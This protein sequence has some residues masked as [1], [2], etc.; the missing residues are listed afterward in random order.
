M[1]VEIEA[2]YKGDL[3]CDARHLD[4]D[5]VITTEAPKDN[6]GGGSKFSPTDLVAA[7]L[8]TCV[9]TIM[10]LYAKRRSIEIEGTKIRIKKEMSDTNPRRIASLDMTITFPKGLSLSEEDRVRLEKIVNTCPVHH[11]LHPDIK[12]PTKFIYA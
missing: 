5:S 7:A 12:T 10:G 2:V 8:S 9:L 4:S 11:S 3:R 1:S 6:G